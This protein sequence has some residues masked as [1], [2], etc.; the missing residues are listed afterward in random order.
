MHELLCFC[1]KACLWDFYTSI[2]KFVTGEDSVGLISTK[3]K[4][5]VFFFN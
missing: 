5:F 4:G 2:F 1:L 3:F